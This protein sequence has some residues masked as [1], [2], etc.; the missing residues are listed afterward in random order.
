ME[1]FRDTRERQYA[2]HHGDDRQ[3]GVKAEDGL[4]NHQFGGKSVE[5]RNAGGGERG[6]PEAGHGD[7][8]GAS[9]AAQLVDL[10]LSGAVDDGAGGEEDEAFIKGVVE[11]MEDAPSYGGFAKAFERGRIVKNGEAGSEGQEHV[12]GLRHRQIG[13][14]AFEVFLRQSHGDPDDHGEHAENNDDPAEVGGR[15]HVVDAEEDAHHAVEARLRGKDEKRSHRSG[16]AAI[17]VGLPEVH[18]YRA[19]FEAERNDE[20]HEGDF[21][22]AGVLQ[23]LGDH[24]H[25]ERAVLAVENSNTDQHEETGGRAEQGVFKARFDRASLFNT[26]GDQRRSGESGDFEEDEKVEQVACADQTV[27]T[28]DQQEEESKEAVESCVALFA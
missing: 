16:R 7:F 27:D 23:P 9:E 1:D 13:D 28:R 24:C 26:E 3:E 6:N 25:V 4:V 15:V 21:V 5:G 12:T 19:A 22:E 10:L 14:E 2:D 17:G 18:R 20:E 11:E 8:H